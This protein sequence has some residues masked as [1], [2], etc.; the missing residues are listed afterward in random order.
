VEELTKKRTQ[1]VSFL[2]TSVMSLSYSPASFVYADHILFIEAS[3]AATGV[4]RG[5]DII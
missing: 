1:L 5:F 4:V 3:W 2:Q